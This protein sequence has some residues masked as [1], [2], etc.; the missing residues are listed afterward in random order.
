MAMGPLIRVWLEVFI[1]ENRIARLP[2]FILQG[3]GDKVTEAAT[4]QGILIGEQTV[5]GTHG[6][7][8]TACHG[9]GDEITAHAAGAD[10][11]DG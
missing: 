6:Q 1:Q 11:G 9:L 10:S 4:R 2:R 5:I 3:Q 7:L 8:M